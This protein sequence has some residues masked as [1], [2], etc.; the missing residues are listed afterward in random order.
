MFYTAKKVPQEQA[1]DDAFM[2]RHSTQGK[3]RQPDVT[4]SMKLAPV[5]EGSRERREEENVAT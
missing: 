2:A 5:S 1:V 4:S 3:P